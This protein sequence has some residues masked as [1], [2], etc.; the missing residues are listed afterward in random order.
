MILVSV[1]S[2]PQIIESLTKTFGE[3]PLRLT[4]NDLVSLPDGHR[5]LR[6]TSLGDYGFVGRHQILDANNPLLKIVEYLRQHPITVRSQDQELTIEETSREGIFGGART[7]GNYEYNKS[8]SADYRDENTIIRNPR[9]PDSVQPL[10]VTGGAAST[11]GD[12]DR[13]R[14]ISGAVPGMSV[15][16]R[17]PA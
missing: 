9:L 3:F 14:Q 12:S 1:P 17:N 2:T 16:I 13:K 7:T 4:D 5:I 11:S 10:T 15:V 8:R 6:D